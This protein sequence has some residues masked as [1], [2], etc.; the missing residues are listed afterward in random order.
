[1]KNLTK[2]S[3]GIFPL[4]VSGVLIILSITITGMNLAAQPGLTL[5]ADA[6]KNTI[7]DGS[8]YQ[9]CITRT[10]QVREKSAGSRS[11]D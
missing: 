3:T 10:L 6:G 8:V 1:M 9:I 7:S 5:Y 4:K 2:M 11:S